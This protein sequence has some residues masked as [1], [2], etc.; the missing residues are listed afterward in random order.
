MISG[1]GFGLHTW[2]IQKNAV[3]FLGLAAV[4]S[5]V[6]VFGQMYEISPDGKVLAMTE[7]GV[8]Y[9]LGAGNEAK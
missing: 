4:D 9:L 8:V 6:P 3:N 2:E 7:C 1:N 5:F